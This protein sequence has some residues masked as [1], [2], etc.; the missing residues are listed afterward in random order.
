MATG[1]KSSDNQVL[2]ELQ[3]EIVD[4]L[5]ES[6]TDV[7]VLT[8]RAVSKGLIPLQGLEANATSTARSGRERAEQFVG[9]V[10][11]AIRGDPSGERTTLFLQI[12]EDLFLSPLSEFIRSKLAGGRKGTGDIHHDASPAHRPGPLHQPPRGAYGG[13]PKLAPAD[14]ED[15]GIVKEGETNHKNDH[16]NS[17]VEV[18]VNAQHKL[19]PANPGGAGFTP[20]S[21]GVIAVQTEHSGN[22][23]VSSEEDPPA[24][25]ETQPHTQ[26]ISSNPMITGV[27]SVA[28]VLEQ[29]RTEQ[30]YQ[31]LKTQMAEMASH[32]ECLQNELSQL[33]IEKEESEQKLKEKDEELERVKREKDA[34]IQLLKAKMEE[35]KCKLSHQERENVALKKH[36]ETEIAKLKEQLESKEKEYHAETLQLTKEKHELELKVEKMYTREEQM[37][38]QISEEEA[39]SA[40]LQA[41]VAEEKQKNTEFK[42]QQEQKQHQEE[43]AA[44]KLQ[45]RESMTENEQLKEELAKL[46]RQHNTEPDTS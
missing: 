5:I 35:L 26:H 36:Y 19:A 31:E 37:K 30:E 15:S 14:N 24:I 13:Q 10:L 41:K 28:P 16:A 12:L 45:H 3:K 1:G 32:G 4:R 7:E 29:L 46:K 38:R 9:K 34:Q 23:A 25:A 39:R 6:G 33:K 11:E 44:L 42:A 8:T 43:M 40:K 27:T 21:N 20:L 22:L 17:G 2:L 18:V